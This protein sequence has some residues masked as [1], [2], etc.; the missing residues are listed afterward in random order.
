MITR[1]SNYMCSVYHFDP[2]IILLD[3][4]QVVDFGRM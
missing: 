2:F 4:F 1:A 3:E